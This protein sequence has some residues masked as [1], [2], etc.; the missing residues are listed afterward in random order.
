MRHVRYG[1]EI[2]APVD[3]VWREL[4]SVAAFPAWNPYIRQVDGTLKPGAHVR[5]RLKPPKGPALILRARLVKL[6]PQRE[7]RWRGWVGIPGLLHREQVFILQ[8]KGEQRTR[9]E[10]REVVSGILV[11]V[12]RHFGFLDSLELGLEAMGYG[13]KSRCEMLACTGRSIGA[14]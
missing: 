14:A 8:P 2:Q 9:L 6:E 5:I 10:Q 12:L 3:I 4:S 11:Y 1:I 7:L 13:M